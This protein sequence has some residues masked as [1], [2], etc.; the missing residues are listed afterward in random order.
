VR[1]PNGNNENANISLTLAF[2]KSILFAKVFTS[3][4]YFTGKILLQLRVSYYTI[5]EP[6][7]IIKQSTEK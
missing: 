6:I 5:K 2:F 3:V 1:S 7:S 4:L